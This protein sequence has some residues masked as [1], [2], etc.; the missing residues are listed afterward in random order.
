MSAA[1]KSLA[2]RSRRRFLARAGVAAAGLAA[3]VRFIDFPH[4]N[5]ASDPVTGARRWGMLIDADKCATGC[6]ACVTACN[7]EHGIRGH[8][9]P[10]TDAQWIRKVTLRE[11]ATGRETSLPLMCQH[12]ENPPCV[13]VCPTGASFRRADGI[14]LVD[15]H[16]CIGC[17]YCMLACPFKA[18]SFVH[19]NLSDQKPWSPRGKGT[20]ESCNLCVH[21]IDEANGRIPACAEACAREGHKAI[22]FGDLKNPTSTLAKELVDDDTQELRADLGLNTGIRYEDL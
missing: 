7:D 2:D 8:G 4:A 1:D 11:K 17:R 18:R 3:G 12:C 6:N 16:S 5:A 22:L 14:V 10:E 19:E 15:K 9:R 21:R 13:D 20:V